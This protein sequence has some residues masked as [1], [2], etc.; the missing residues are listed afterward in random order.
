M[1]PPLRGSV[2]PPVGCYGSN[3]LS[4]YP[5]LAPVYFSTNRQQNQASTTV[6]TS[7]QVL[8]LPM[9]LATLGGGANA[10][11]L[12]TAFNYQG[13]L[14]LH[15]VPVTGSYDLKFVLYDTVSGGSFLYP[16]LTNLNV[17]VTSGLFATTLD[18]GSIHFNGAATWL[19]LSVRTNGSGAFQTLSP[20][21][22]LYPVP[23]AIY[24]AQA[25]Y[26]S[27][28]W[29]AN[30]VE[31]SAVTSGGIATNQVVKSLNGLKDFVTLAV[32]PNVTL[33]PSGNTLTL[34]SS[35]DWHIAGNGG[36]T[37]GTHFVGTTDNRPLE[38]RANNLQTLWLQGNAAGH[39]VVAGGPGNYVLAGMLGATISGGKNNNFDT[40]GN[41]STIAGGADNQIYLA[42]YSV[43]GGGNG[44]FV[45]GSDAATIAG[46]A[47][48]R[49]WDS[50]LGATVGGGTNNV[51]SSYSQYS[52]IAGGYNNRIGDMTTH[53]GAWAAALGGGSANFI[54]SNAHY[55]TIG[56]GERNLVDGGATHAMIP[57]GYSNHVSGYYGLAAGRRARAEHTGAF[58]WADSQN[59]EFSSDRNNQ[60]KVRSAG[61][62][63]IVAQSSGLTPAACRIEST[64]A[65][66][67]GLFVTQTS[68]DANLVVANP[69]AGDLFKGYYGAGGGSLAFRVDNDGDVTAKS[70]N[71]TSDRH[72]KENFAA[73][74]ARAVLA[75]V[76][77]L[78]ISRWNFKAD[79]TLHLGPMAQDFH[80][81][82][83]VGPDDKHIATVDADG[84]ALAA[85]QGLNQKVDAKEA[86]IKELEARL[87]KLERLLTEKLGGVQ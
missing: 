59:A 3:G 40:G 65:S 50:A 24:A 68:S 56:G 23:N 38:L 14:A 21:Q 18:F 35:T 10:S 4:G 73:V 12:G 55:S 2:S 19:E 5:E 15:G 58:V 76:A 13:Q 8:V 83:G 71:P 42:M 48:N 41:Y 37:A 32:G 86:R 17:G 30:N 29:S 25:D 70:F 67:V 69:G 49:I 44:N 75:Q 27:S 78:P 87:A 53:D 57:G 77:A 7:K 39:N 84:V 22:R 43:I 74:D 82:F 11:P 34:A 9:L 26:A 80:A 81:A 33:T 60:F 52:T 54:S 64:S 16:L 51:V 28:A 46:G 31:A 1:P 20:R 6:M 36:T 85:I 79:Q 66:G 61:G 45:G 62:V 72:A 47:L 63:H